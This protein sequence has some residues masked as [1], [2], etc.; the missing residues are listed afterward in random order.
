MH[1]ILRA[2]D[3]FLES[4]AVGRLAG[5]RAA[6]DRGP[7]RRRSP[8]AVADPAGRAA[9]PGRADAGDVQPPDRRRQRRPGPGR[10]QH[11][12]PL[13]R[14]EADRAGRLRR[15]DVDAVRHRH[16]RAA[17]AAGGGDGADRAPG[18]SRRAVRLLRRVLAG[19]LRLSAVEL[20]PPSRSARADADRAVH[21][22]RDRQPA[23]RQLRPDQ[24]ADGRHRLHGRRS[25]LPSCA[26]IWLSR[27]EEL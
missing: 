11:A 12:E 17:G 26:A 1:A 2:I 14:D 5:R 4:P 8:A 3:A 15:D 19:H 22:G 18:R 16:L 7:D 20:R 25:S 9:V 13:H 24:P 10:D 21:A 23:D 27:Q 6:G